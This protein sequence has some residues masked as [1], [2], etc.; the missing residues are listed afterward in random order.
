MILL[1]RV[2]PKDV[3]CTAERPTYAL[4]PGSTLALPNPPSCCRI[5]P[6]TARST[7]MSSTGSSIG[8][9]A[10]A[11]PPAHELRASAAAIAQA[12]C[13]ERGINVS[14]GWRLEREGVRMRRNP[15]CL[16]VWLSFV[17]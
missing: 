2:T 12:P 10:R 13:R 5:C 16:F 3:A 11:P 4:S 8:S 15:R 14:G 6:H 9:S 7:M 17:L 1:A